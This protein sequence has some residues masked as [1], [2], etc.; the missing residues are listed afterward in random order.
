MNHGTKK[1]RYMANASL[2][3]SDIDWLDVTGRVHVD[4]STSTEENVMLQQILCLLVKLIY[5]LNKTDDRHS[6]QI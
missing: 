5:R 4:N 1:Q 3:I 2:K 6:M